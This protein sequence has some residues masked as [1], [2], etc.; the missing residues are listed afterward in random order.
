MNILLT[1]ALKSIYDALPWIGERDLKKKINNQLKIIEKT[2]NLPETDQYISKEFMD[3][4]LF[5]LDHGEEKFNILSIQSL[6]KLV[7]FN[8]IPVQIKYS[9]DSAREI[10]Q[11]IT[12][13]VIQLINLNN[14]HL[15]PPILQIQSILILNN[16]TNIHSSLL[17]AIVNSILYIRSTS[18]KKSTI[19]SCQAVLSQIFTAIFNKFNPK[20]FNIELE[21]LDTHSKNHNLTPSYYILYAPPLSKIDSVY[22]FINSSLK[23]RPTY[24]SIIESSPYS[25][26]TII[27]NNNSA[28][29]PN[30]HYQDID[31]CYVYVLKKL[32]FINNLST[33]IS[34]L[35]F[36]YRLFLTIFTPS[37]LS[38][39][40]SIKIYYL[41]FKTIGFISM[42]N[43]IL[44]TNKELLEIVSE[45]LKLLIQNHCKLFI[46]EIGMLIECVLLP[47]LDSSEIETDIKYIVYFV[48]N[49]RF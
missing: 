39:I 28:F 10:V 49:C 23:I 38:A 40:F 24:K 21:S 26:E 9:I 37:K 13:K 16:N 32:N 46:H 47:I 11:T 14:E 42:L 22:S 29:Y 5:C 15:Y 2:N 34:D 30:I 6:S 36:F 7:E 19:L 33:P 1:N 3:I 12:E 4:L 48:L 8:Y 45:L 25:I 43:C 41:E 18:A 44:S 27:N 17:V 35:I 20:D 31:I